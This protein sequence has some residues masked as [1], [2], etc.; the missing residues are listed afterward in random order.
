MT[1]YRSPDGRLDV[2][3]LRTARA[4]GAT[5][6]TIGRAAGVSRERIR[7]VL[8]RAAARERLGLTLR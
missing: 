4:T 1:P 3:A 6:K 7:A 8:Q 2:H 5:L